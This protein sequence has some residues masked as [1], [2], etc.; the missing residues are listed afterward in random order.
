[1]EKISNLRVCRGNCSKNVG[2][3]V[4]EVYLAWPLKEC[5]LICANVEH[6]F[7]SCMKKPPVGE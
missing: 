5:V 1:M 3:A 7:D 6:F 2:K 4:S